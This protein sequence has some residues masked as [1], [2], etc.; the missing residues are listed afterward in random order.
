MIS[1]VLLLCFGVEENVRFELV[2]IS[3]DFNYSS[4]RRSFGI[5]EEKQTCIVCDVQQTSNEDFQIYQQIVS[6]VIKEQLPSTN[7][8]NLIRYIYILLNYQ[9]C[10][11]C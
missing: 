11:I 9:F 5:I 3:N 1:F 7:K 4:S 10:N 2:I 8:F 6:S